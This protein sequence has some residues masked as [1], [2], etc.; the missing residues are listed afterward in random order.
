MRQ[1]L[2]IIVQA[3]LVCESKNECNISN[4]DAD[5]GDDQ[6]KSTPRDGT[7]I[8]LFGAGALLERAA[9]V[10][11]HAS[12]SQSLRNLNRDGSPTVRHHTI[13]F[14]RTLLFHSYSLTGYF[15]F[16]FSPIQPRYQWFPPS[17]IE[18]HDSPVALE[19]KPLTTVIHVN[20]IGM[21]LS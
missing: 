19:A 10:Q 21:G 2:K 17:D 9:E 3:C 13:P 4:T 8:P 18:K 11:G 14:L 7:I 1:N 15:F 12:L 16:S 6:S 5:S 20:K